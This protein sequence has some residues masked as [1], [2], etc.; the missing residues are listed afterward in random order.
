M[1]NEY[2]LIYTPYITR[3]ACASGP[4]STDSRCSACGFLA[5]SIAVN[6]NKDLFRHGFLLS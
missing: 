1:D 5:R 3:K 4:L 2:V 6:F